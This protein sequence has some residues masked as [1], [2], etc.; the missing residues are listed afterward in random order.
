M[1][2]VKAI[3]WSSVLALGLTTPAGAI[4]MLQLDASPS[5]YNVGD[6]SIQATANPFQ[7]Y[8]L[9]DTTSS[10][11]SL[12]SY[13]YVSVAIINQSGVP[14]TLGNT[15]FGSFSISGAGIA[16]TKSYSLSD[17]VFGNPP[18]ESSNFLQ[19][20]DP[21][22][23]ASHGVFPTYFAEIKFKFDSTKTA[24]AYNTA[25][26]PGGLVAGP[27]TLDYRSWNIDTT[28]LT[29]GYA[30]H[31]D[32]YNEALKDGDTDVNN[33]APFS[34][35]AVSGGTTTKVPDTSTSV[36]LLGLALL[37]LAGLRYRFGG[38]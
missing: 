27:G 32:L 35:D 26:H 29:A 3:L 9:A 16:G 7:L 23:L 4:P 12:S 18:I 19:P 13:Y 36:T 6:E 24:A 25:D 17:L 21:G 28:G 33:F 38:K 11:F 30:L 20:K 8:A 5:I 15:A 14:M 2:N 10:K 37:G 34:H 1:F 31:F 22:D